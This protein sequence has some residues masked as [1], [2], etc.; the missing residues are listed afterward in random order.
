MVADSEFQTMQILEIILGSQKI[1]VT[2]AF[3]TEEALKI[4]NNKPT[5]KCGNRGF[6]LYFISIDLPKK[7]GL[8]FCRLLKDRMKSD[9]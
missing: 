3:S 5:C 1:E 4:I 2:R 6:V 8:W 7:G 9:I